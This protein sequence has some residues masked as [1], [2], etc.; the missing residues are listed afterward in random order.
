MFP[1]TIFFQLLSTHTAMATALQSISPL[2]SID[3]DSH[4]IPSN[5]TCARQRDKLTE[6]DPGYHLQ[7]T[8]LHVP[9]HKPT[10]T[11]AP[12]IHW[13]VE[14][15][16]ARRVAMK[17]VTADPSSMEK[18]RHGEWRVNLLPRLRIMLYPYVQSA[19]TIPA[20]PNA[21]IQR[22]TGVLPCSCVVDHMR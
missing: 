7:L 14:T 9:E 21:R 1:V 6:I 3:D 22:G 18:P 11:V 19:I 2:R 10:P 12:V 8:V 5:N 16:R 13:V 4:Q 17:T 20:P 15:G